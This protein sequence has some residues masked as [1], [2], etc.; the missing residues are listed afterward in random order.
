[1]KI[2]AF[3]TLALFLLATGGPAEARKT[4]TRIKGPVPVKVSKVVDGDTLEVVAQIWID[5]RLRTKVRILGI[6]AP[7]RRGRCPAERTQAKTAHMAL[8]ELLKGRRAVLKDIRYG[9]YAGR[10]VAR[11]FNRDGVDVGKALL[12]AG[13]VRAYRGRRRK[14]WC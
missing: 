12:T 4:R 14:P 5:Q 2:G 8:R 11:V 10:V 6:D 3:A 13:L 9:K 7:E 1:M